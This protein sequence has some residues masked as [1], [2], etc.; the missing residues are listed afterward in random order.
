MELVRLN[1]IQRDSG[2]D[3]GRDW[4]SFMLESVI[5]GF[6]DYCVIDSLRTHSAN[7]ALLLAE[8]QT[9]VKSNIDGVPQSC[10]IVHYDL[11]PSNVLAD[12][13]RVTGV[14][15]WESTQGGDPAFDLVT[16]LYYRYSSKPA[17]QE[18]WEYLLKSSSLPAIRVYLAHVIVRQVDWSIRHHTRDEVERYLRRS[19]EIVHNSSER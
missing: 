2:I 6:R 18:L 12:G 19:R 15:D 17:R 3:R 14:I 5:Q 13:N 9:T 8:A 11:N 10:G 16:L 1:Q 7:T 4:R